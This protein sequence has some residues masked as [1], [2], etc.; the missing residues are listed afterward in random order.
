MEIKDNDLVHYVLQNINII[1]IWTQEMI[2][3]DATE[4]KNKNF[5]INC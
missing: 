2:I 4:S 5:Y 1:D 3:F